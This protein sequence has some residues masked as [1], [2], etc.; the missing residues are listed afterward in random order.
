[1]ARPPFPPI[2]LLSVP[3]F[4]PADSHS[5]GLR[6]GPISICA[7][8]HPAGDGNQTTE[9]NRGSEDIGESKMRSA[10]IFGIPIRTLL[11]LSLS[12]YPTLAH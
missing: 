1:M 6:S 11:K 2:P 5:M 7:G 3:S 10:W 8:P 4:W 9:Q 12:F